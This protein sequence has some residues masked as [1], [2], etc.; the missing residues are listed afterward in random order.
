M[1]EH[2]RLGEKDLDNMLRLAMI[3]DTHLIAQRRGDVLWIH[4]WEISPATGKLG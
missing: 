1:T 2:M 4:Y 3:S